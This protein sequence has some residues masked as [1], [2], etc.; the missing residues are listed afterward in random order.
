[1][2]LYVAR[3]LEK[4]KNV[5]VRVVE[6]DATQADKAVS[7]LER[8][9][10]ING[11]GLSRP[12]LEEA[13]VPSADLVIAITH[14]DRTNMLICK[15]SKQMGAARALALIN[16]PEL[17]SLSRDLDIDAVLDPKALTVSRILMKMR[18]G[19]ILALQS[20]EDGA[21][22]IAEGVT[23]DTSPLIGKPLGY[24]DLPEGIT[25]AAILRDNEVLFPGPGVTPRANDHVLLF[26][27]E[28][29]TKKV[30]QFFRVSQDF[31]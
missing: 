19:R 9:I 10:V 21:A 17:N 6:A 13:G 26:Y 18:R 28:G 24:D 2:G 23:L 8:T 29:M 16:S 3:K 7:E 1:M 31:F 25:A 5:R 22:E 30:E 15:L 20:L 12:I 4:Q 14:D 27:E 11:D